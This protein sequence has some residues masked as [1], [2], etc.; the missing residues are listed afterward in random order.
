METFPNS[1]IVGFPIPDVI[2]LAVAYPRMRRLHVDCECILD[3]RNVCS[4][5]QLMKMNVFHPTLKG[6][7]FPPLGGK[8]ISFRNLFFP[9]NSN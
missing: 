4:L 8:F 6:I 3:V 5:I 1:N 9:S 2:T 7:H